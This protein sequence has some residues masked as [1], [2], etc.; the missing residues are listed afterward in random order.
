MLVIAA[1]VFGIIFMY[2][3]SVMRFILFDSVMAKECHIREGWI[4]RQ[5][6]GLRYFLWKLFYLLVT[7][8]GLIV[9][10]G[11]PAAFA[12]AVGWLKEP[13]EHVSLWC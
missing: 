11:V 8:A 1:L 5:G 13:K 3:S 12:F 7:L 9:L 2:I 10:V 6:P 4:R